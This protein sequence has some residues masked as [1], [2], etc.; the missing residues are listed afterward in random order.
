MAEHKRLTQKDIEKSIFRPNDATMLDGD[1]SITPI[2]TVYTIMHKHDELDEDGFPLLLDTIYE[3]PGGKERLVLAAT[4]EDA[5]AKKTFNGKRYRYFAKVN[6]RRDLYD[7]AGLYVEDEKWQR[8]NTRQ[9]G[10]L[11]W[12]FREVNLR[13]FELYLSFLKTNN[14]SWL[15][16][17]NRANK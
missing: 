10:Q 11:K 14:K 15:N 1:N 6:N 16:N 2:V 9:S 7:P 5:Y 4:F 12:Q 13:V 8:K 3:Q 17:A